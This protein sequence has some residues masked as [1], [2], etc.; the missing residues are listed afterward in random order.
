M[1]KS[2][3]NPSTFGSMLYG[4]NWDLMQFATMREIIL[5]SV[6]PILFV[7]S[8]YLPWQMA[9]LSEYNPKNNF[10][11]NQFYYGVSNKFSFD[12]FKWSLASSIQCHIK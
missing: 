2:I 1:L 9:Y 11:S 12:D 10:Y 8:N 6:A 7:L 4:V 3:W 5:N